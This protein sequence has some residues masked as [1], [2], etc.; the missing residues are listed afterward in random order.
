MIGIHTHETITKYTAL[1]IES[2]KNFTVDLQ[3]HCK[4]TLL[5]G[6]IHPI[7]KK[8]WDL[9]YLLTLSG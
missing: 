1:K 6:G 8:P 2:S 7:M 3:H 5:L 4:E 9:Q